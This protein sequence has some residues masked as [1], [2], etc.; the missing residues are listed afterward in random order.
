MNDKSVTVYQQTKAL[1]HNDTVLER[2]AALVGGDSNA[3]HYVTS[4]LNAVAINERLQ[5]CEPKSIVYSAMN[6]AALHLTV[7]PSQG[8]AYLVPY[9]SKCTFIIG[10]KGMI[11]LAHRTGKYRLMHDNVLTQKVQVNPITGEWHLT[12]EPSDEKI[13]TFFFRL[14][15]GIEH[16]NMMTESEVKEHAMKY[17]YAYKKGYD[18][19]WKTDFDKMASKTVIRQSL[20]K[21]GYFDPSTLA[22]M[23]L[24]EQLADDEQLNEV[25]VTDDGEIIDA[26]TAD[27]QPNMFDDLDADSF[28]AMMAKGK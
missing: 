1:L 11:Q 10:Y 7:E 5:E 24:E 15:D 17:S 8:H 28:N 18:S 23:S 3:R 21:Y 22:A 19:P 9:G 13:Y 14:V 26:E 20:S 12:G 27:E 16:F 4:V 2:F 6:A 25:F